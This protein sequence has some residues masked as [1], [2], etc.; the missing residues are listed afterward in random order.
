MD[1]ALGD[2]ISAQNDY[3]DFIGNMAAKQMASD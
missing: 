2:V 1:K 3:H